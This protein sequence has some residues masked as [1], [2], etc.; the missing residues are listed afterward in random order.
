MLTYCFR[1]ISYQCNVNG[2]QKHYLP[3]K[4][5]KQRK[6]FRVVA[7]KFSNQYFTIIGNYYIFT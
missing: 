5:T 4:F 2:G 3:A 6:S 7:F 1:Y